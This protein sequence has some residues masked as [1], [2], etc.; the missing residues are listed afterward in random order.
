[1][2]IR[3]GKVIRFHYALHDPVKE[4]IGRVTFIRDTVEAPVSDDT[5]RR[6]P[7]AERSR[8]L[9]TCL[10]ADGTTRSFYDAGLTEVRALSRMARVGLFLSG[11]R[12]RGE[13]PVESEGTKVRKVGRRWVRVFNGRI[14]PS[15]LQD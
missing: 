13:R 3:P 1:M 6:N 11:V 4:R 15:P 10:M 14:I 2:T 5:L 8:Y 12:F 9:L 7:Y